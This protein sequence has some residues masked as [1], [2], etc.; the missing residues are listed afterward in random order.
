MCKRVN[1][2]FVISGLISS[3]DYK[4]KLDGGFAIFDSIRLKDGV[5]ETIPGK[6][7]IVAS[8]LLDITKM[9]GLCD[10]KNIFNGNG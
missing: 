7:N 8:S 9:F 4:G 1:D 5:S 6:W 3:I 2:D 10:G